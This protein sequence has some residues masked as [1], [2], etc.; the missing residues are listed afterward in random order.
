MPDAEIFETLDYNFDDARAAL[1]RDGLP[2][3][4]RLDQRSSTSAT[5]HETERSTSRA[6][7]SASCATS[8]RPSD[9]LHQRPIYVERREGTTQVEVALQYNDGYSE[10]VFSF[11]NNINTIDGG[12]HLTGFRAALTRVLNGYARKTASSR[13]NDANLTGDDVREGLTAVISVKLPE[14]QF[15]GQTKAKLGNAEVEGAGP[16]RVAEGLDAVPRGE[17]AATARRII[18]KCAHRGA[19]PRGRRKARDL[20]SRKSALEGCAARQA[21]R[22]LRSATRRDASSSSSR[23]TPPAARPSRAA[24]A[25]SRP[26]LPLR[27]KILNVEKARLDKMLAQRGDPAADHRARRGHRRRRSTSRKLRYHR[28]IIMTDADVDGSHIRTLLLTFFFRH[29]PELDRG[30]PPLHR[31]A[32]AV[33]ASARARSRATLQRRRADRRCASSRRSNART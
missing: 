28:I 16:D 33:T 6:A 1:P 8:T 12:T 11:A 24:T 17:P 20:V 4:G 3:Q 13:T 26:I 22:L 7:S 9:V 32:A 29:M 18:E 10:S 21:G 23:A 2:E 31:A 14:P 25:A 5:G 19:R 30:R 15:E 27:G